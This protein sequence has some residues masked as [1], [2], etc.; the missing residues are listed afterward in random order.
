MLGW[1]NVNFVR[2]GSENELI[3]RAFVRRELLK[4]ATGDLNHLYRMHCNLGEV[5][6]DNYDLAHNFILV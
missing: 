4:L 5:I 1:S 2:V 6:T 3:D